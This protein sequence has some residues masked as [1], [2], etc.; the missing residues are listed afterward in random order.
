MGFDEKFCFTP[1]DSCPEGYLVDNGGVL[2][3]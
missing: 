2:A 1:H 3:K